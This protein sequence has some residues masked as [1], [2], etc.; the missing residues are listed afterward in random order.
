MKKRKFKR[1]DIVV[2]TGTIP[3]TDVSVNG[4]LGIVCKIDDSLFTHI[5]TK[6]I[7]GERMSGFWIFDDNLEKIDHLTEEEMEEAGIEK[8]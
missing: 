2:I 4:E 3:I 1:G 7:V 5:P 6:V 8:E